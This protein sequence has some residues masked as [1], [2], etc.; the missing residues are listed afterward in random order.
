M[1]DI[2][3]CAGT[4]Q[5]LVARQLAAVAAL[6]VIVMTV[7]GVV[8]IG[9][10]GY[11]LIELTLTRVDDQLLTSASNTSVRAAS[12][13][14]AQL[15]G[16]L[17]RLAQKPELVAA[18]RGDDQSLARAEL[19]DAASLLGLQAAG[20]IDA[21]NRA[22]DT[23]VS[24][25]ELG[26]P[27]GWD[28]ALLGDAAVQASIGRLLDHKS[29]AIELGLTNGRDTPALYAIAPVLDNGQIAGLLFM[30]VS[31]DRLFQI[32]PPSDTGGLVFYDINGRARRSRPLR[33]RNIL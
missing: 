11:R 19:R 2:G 22:L 14:A 12:L 17:T 4:R 16:S 32:V 6:P 5:C 20:V 8:C 28:T 24:G 23:A 33:P 13:W 18:L 25:P 1:E 26:A 31:L 3:T 21:S 15:V 30:G 7:I 10:L 29:A 9:A 27:E